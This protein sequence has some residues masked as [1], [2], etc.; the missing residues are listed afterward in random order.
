MN[1]TMPAQGSETPHHMN[2]Q[3]QMQNM[4]SQM[5]TQPRP[6]EVQ[7]P[8]LISKPGDMSIFIQ[9]GSSQLTVPGQDPSTAALS[10]VNLQ[11]VYANSAPGNGVQ[12]HVT[13]DVAMKNMYM[14]QRWMQ[15]N[16]GFNQTM[17]GLANPADGDSDMQRPVEGPLIQQVSAVSAEAQDGY[18]EGMRQQVPSNKLPDTHGKPWQT[19]D[20]I[21]HARDTSSAKEHTNTKGIPQDSQNRALGWGDASVIQEQY[22]SLID[23]MPSDPDAVIAMAKPHIHMDPEF[24]KQLGGV[25]NELEDKA[26]S[27]RGK[28]DQLQ[29]KL[30]KLHENMG[31]SIPSKQTEPVKA[32]DNV[33]WEL[34]LKE[35]QDFQDLVSYEHREKRRKFKAVIVAS[36]KQASKFES[37]KMAQQLEATR[38]QRTICKN[39][40]NVVGLYW[41]KIE[42]FAWE[43]L[44]RDLQ[45][46]LVQKKRMRL[47]KFV[48]DAIKISISKNDR[49][50][51]GKKSRK[52]RSKISSNHEK[53]SKKLKRTNMSEEKFTLK[54]KDN[55]ENLQHAAI[56]NLESNKGIKLETDSTLKSKGDVTFKA[57]G[58]RTLKK[59]HDDT[60]NGADAVDED[61]FVVSEEME[62][63][64]RD[65][66]L[67]DMAM[68][69]EE[70]QE[71]NDAD[72][73]KHELNAL[74]DDLN[75]PIEEILKRYQQEAEKFKEE[76]S[77]CEEPAELE[78]GDYSMDENELSDAEEDE[79]SVQTE[80]SDIS[81][82]RD[83]KT[84]SKRPG[85]G[86]S[87]DGLGGESGL[88][89]GDK[90]D[91]EVEFTL[92]D[93]VFKMQEDEDKNLDDEMSDEHSDNET[94]KQERVKEISALEDE[95]NI[96]I[97]ELLAR[98]K[99]DGGYDD[100]D[101]SED[102]MQSSIED[103]ATK[104]IKSNADSEMDTETM[105]GEST[106][107]ETDTSGAY[108]DSSTDD[109]DQVQVPSL[110]KATLRP[111]QVEGLRWLASLY[112]QKSNGILA[113][114]MGL[115]KTLQTIALLAHLACEHGNWGPHLIV[116]P[117]S[118]LINWE[119]E[120]KKF[121]PGFN[122]LSYYGTPAERAKKRVGWNKQ[123]AFNVCIAS[124]ATVVQDAHMMKRKSWVYMILDEAQNIKNFNSKRWQTLLTFNTEGRILLTGTPLQNSL[125]ELWSLMHFI[126]PEIFSSHS[127]FKEWFSD[128]L[129]ES[130]EREQASADGRIKDS[131]TSDL[132]NKLHMVLRPY[133]LRRLKKDVEKQMP[134]KY[135]HVIKCYLSRRQRVLYDEFI[136]SRSAVEAL[137][138][139]SYRSMLFVLMQL[140]KICNHPD[141]LQSRP[142]E[143][144]FYDPSC[145]EDVEIPMMFLLPDKQC[146]ARLYRHEKLYIAPTHP[147]RLMINN[148]R[149]KS[150]E[151]LPLPVSFIRNFRGG[152]VNLE[153]VFRKSENAYDQNVMNL[154]IVSPLLPEKGML[155]GNTSVKRKAM[156]S[157]FLMKEGISNNICAPLNPYYECHD[158]VASGSADD[159]SMVVD[160]FTPSSQTH[161]T[162]I[163]SI[164]DD[165]VDMDN[166]AAE[167]GE[168]TPQGNGVYIPRDIYGSACNTRNDIVR[169]DQGEDQKSAGPWG[170][171]ETAEEIASA[172]QYPYQVD[173]GI[174]NR[175]ELLEVTDS[176][177]LN[178]FTI[179]KKPQVTVESLRAFVQPTVDD[180]VE[181]NWW[182][183][184][185]FVCT[186]GIRID[187][188]PRRVY[189]TGPGGVSW[190]HRQEALLTRV[191][192]KIFRKSSVNYFRNT[193]YSIEHVRGIQ[194][195]LF[196]PRSLLHDDC[197]KFVVLGRLLQKLKNE[198]HRC[199]LYTQ[200]SKMLDILE[201]WINYMGFTYVRLDGS[202]KVDMRQRIVTRF[203]EN[204][205]IFLFISSTRAGGVGLTLTGADTVIFY[206]TDWNP[207]MDRQAMDRCHRIGQTREVNVYRLVSEHTVEE[208]IWR[209]QLQKRRLDDIVVDKGNFDSEHHDWFSN[210]DTLM[211][212]LKTHTSDGHRDEEDI[213]G[214][215]VLH[216]SEAPEPVAQSVSQGSSKKIINMLAEAEDEDD[217]MALINRTKETE[218]VDQDFHTDINTDIVS[219]IPSLVAYCIQFMLKY[220]TPTLMAQKEEMAIRI[221][222]EEYDSAV[223]DESDSSDNSEP[224]D[225]ERESE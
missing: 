190:K 89:E 67:L 108:E 171:S 10:N 43:R 164:S 21:P 52:R 132:V 121:C 79:S 53:A 100:G 71:E 33:I 116:V 110:I 99:A 19:L 152:N 64:A 193:R 159:N 186:N 83:S 112:R 96:P 183:I 37:K 142:V 78:E 120:F 29:K 8:Q 210:V 212:I 200:F 192:T 166:M 205:K 128:P 51:H 135:E 50:K 31:R 176:F 194:K 196:P 5:F 97:E 101:M 28:I 158:T 80:Q 141:Q 169:N 82:K 86:S 65:D 185:R 195:L 17:Q 23:N 168:S 165:E 170:S 106:Y 180:L 35:M 161:G 223:E 69:R 26:L 48:E 111:Y 202:T 157:S 38:Q 11:D 114:E 151:R 24:L 207:A 140:R 7:A 216:E 154:P 136:S 220:T 174:V 211:T 163:S 25:Y 75:V 197:G 162:S 138:N 184:S 84:D 91:E 95:A 58:R 145:M 115:G 147:E 18:I 90:E 204:V 122:I 119:M 126:L 206:D 129:T 32:L 201:N 39:I 107:T 55:K 6:M 155:H 45:I 131:Q 56:A 209:K 15:F 222:A 182:M 59:Q 105:H 60:S 49:Y 113:D 224:G 134:S 153:R 46:T 88:K 213:Y 144:P 118:V 150:K 117:T 2:W 221:Q 3:V 36:Q 63:M 27:I 57:E 124:Y 41:K 217:S 76:H 219:A 133:L 20:T 172:R 218:C 149:T 104:S 188:N 1:Y 189:M 215:K 22:E 214:K 143:S 40:S 137:N 179:A 68:E 98:Y 177:F 81:R 103:S 72:N 109:E 85:S 123:Y 9:D 47:D 146:D 61:E 139:P 54:S 173:T 198:G 175:H 14:P 34:I 160:D 191:R 66:A 181:R 77:S 125:Q 70:D 102:S 13:A 178:M 74:E 203:N 225:G 156:I 208:N 4:R 44:K 92:N 93:D 187:C 30:S 12:G 62:K 16:M 167:V 42:K 148:C 87:K 199:L 130:I 73:K 127:E 94:G